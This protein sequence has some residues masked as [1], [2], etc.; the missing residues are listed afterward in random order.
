MEE[1]VHILKLTEAMA[2]FQSEG[3]EKRLNRKWDQSLIAPAKEDRPVPLNC[4]CE[5]YQG[6]R[7]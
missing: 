3:G 4:L 5:S 1:I 2:G 6:D 7:S